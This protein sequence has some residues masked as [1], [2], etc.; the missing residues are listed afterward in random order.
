MSL[1]LL[2]DAKS[3]CHDGLQKDPSNEELKKVATKIDAQMS[4]RLKYDAEV[5][6][7]TT[8]AKVIIT[9]TIL[10]SQRKLS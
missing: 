2:N 9:G 10:F 7:A 5:S 4:E 6:N 3:Y 1:N 8:L